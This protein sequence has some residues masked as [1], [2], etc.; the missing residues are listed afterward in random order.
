[1]I[2][3]RRFSA[4]SLTLLDAGFRA[5]SSLVTGT[6]EAF[7]WDLEPENNHIV[8]CFPFINRKPKSI[9]MA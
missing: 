2:T 5:F 7:C 9:Q 6:L 1:M 8:V 4:A 3:E